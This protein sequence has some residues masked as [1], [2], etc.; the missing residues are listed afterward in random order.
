VRLREEKRARAGS[1]NGTQESPGFN[2]N[3]KKSGPLIMGVKGLDSSSPSLY[4]HSSLI[5]ILII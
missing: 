1:R 5:Y 4:S 2:K 3:I